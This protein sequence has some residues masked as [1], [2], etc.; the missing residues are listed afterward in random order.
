M[1]RLL[2]LASAALL[3]PT[4]AGDYSDFN[5]VL[6]GYNLPCGSNAAQLFS[7]SLGACGVPGNDGAGRDGARCTGGVS[8]RA[9]WELYLSRCRACRG[10]K[11]VLVVP[12]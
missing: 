4:A 11:C 2:L 12:A 3:R 5:P 9:T 10:V 7:Y 1:A 8:Y 6:E